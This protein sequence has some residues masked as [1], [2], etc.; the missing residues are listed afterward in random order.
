ML[1]RFFSFSMKEIRE[2]LVSYNQRNKANTKA[3]WSNEYYLPDGIFPYDWQ[4]APDDHVW[5]IAELPS[6]EIITLPQKSHAEEITNIEKP[7]SVNFLTQKDNSNSLNNLTP[8][9]ASIFPSNSPNSSFQEKQSYPSSIFSAKMA[10]PINEYLNKGNQWHFPMTPNPSFD[11]H[12]TLTKKLPNRRLLFDELDV[13]VFTLQRHL[14]NGW[15]N[16][17]PGIVP[18]ATGY[19]CRRC[20]NKNQKLFARFS[21]Y[22]CKGECVYCR[23]CLMMGKVTSCSPLFLWNGQ[24]AEAKEND[25]G[26]HEL[27]WKGTLSFFQQK[28]SNKLCEVITNFYNGKLKIDQFLIWAVCGSG[29]TEMLFQGIE[30]ALKMGFRVLI[31]TPRT[32]VVLELEPRFKKAFPKTVIHAFY[33][34]G[35]DRFAQGEL[36]IST[37][38]QLLRSYEAFDLVIID[39]VDA[40]PYTADEKLH[41]AVANAKKEKALTIFVT[42]TPVEKMKRDAELGKIICVKVARRFHRHPLPVPRNVWIGQWK[43]QLDK[44][45]IPRKVLGWIQE[46]LKRDKQIFLFVPTVRTIHGVVHGLKSLIHEIVEG[47]HAEDEN[48]REKVSRFRNGDIRVLVTTTILERG[49]TVK[50]VQVAVLGAEAPIF[51]ESALVQI[52]GRAGR[53]P[54][55]PTGEVVYFHYGKTMEMVKAIKHIKEMNTLGERQLLE[56]GLLNVGN[57]HE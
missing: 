43:K 2:I 20:G 5:F 56:E 57:D 40:F 46:H 27:A 45:K 6:H 24:D 23:S 1:M 53:N 26:K 8:L 13:D 3:P 14:A 41:W 7:N 21:C 11:P 9:E 12:P 32:D 28:A 30:I 29:K 36:V 50:G 49:V 34:G 37:T 33:G 16:F 19:Q 39:E 38:H 48:R 17:Q 18:F 42:A 35:D 54:D 55:E 10:K 52:A 15:V 44:G 31:A 22:R 47:V 25:C 4:T 51:I